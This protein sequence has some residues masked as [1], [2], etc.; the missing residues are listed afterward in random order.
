M[1]NHSQELRSK[2]TLCRDNEII[3]DG[4]LH[5]TILCAVECDYVIENSLNCV[6][7]SARTHDAHRHLI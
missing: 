5:G 1:P 4:Q 7:K 6:L 3:T 2:A